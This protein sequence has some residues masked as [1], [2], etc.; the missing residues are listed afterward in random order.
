MVTDT[1]VLMHNERIELLVFWEVVVDN[2]TTSRIKY[3]E[4]VNNSLKLVLAQPSRVSII[5]EHV[6]RDFTI[7]ENGG[8]GF[9]DIHALDV[10][11]LGD[12]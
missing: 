11:V 4:I 9:I 5:V 7:H 3:L 12:A 8:L 6:I 10:G 1:S 2:R